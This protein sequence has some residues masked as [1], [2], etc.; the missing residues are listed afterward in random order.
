LLGVL[1][2]ELELGQLGR[3]ATPDCTFEPQRPTRFD[4]ELGG[5]TNEVVPRRRVPMA[6]P[7]ERRRLVALQKVQGDVAHEAG[8]VVHLADELGLRLGINARAPDPRRSL[9]E[10]VGVLDRDPLHEQVQVQGAATLELDQ[11]GPPD[12]RPPVAERS[13]ELLQVVSAVAAVDE[14]ARREDDVEPRRVL[15]RVEQEHL[16]RLDREQPGAVL[17]EVRR[18]APTGPKFARRE[19]QQPQVLGPAGAPRGPLRPDRVR[20]SLMQIK[21]TGCIPPAL[22]CNLGWCRVRQGLLLVRAPAVCVDGE[23]SLSVGVPTGLPDL[24]VTGPCDRDLGEPVGPARLAF[25]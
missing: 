11:H 2:L 22:L 3:D 10:L 5:G 17:A 21:G 9:V 16:G 18:P 4:P 1:V 24:A 15:H 8:A 14:L 13:P 23:W 25:V 7:P 6:A 20:N 19:V 12:R